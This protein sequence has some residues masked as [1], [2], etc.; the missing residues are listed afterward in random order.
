MLGPLLTLLITISALAE[1]GPFSVVIQPPEMKFCREVISFAEKGGSGVFFQPNIDK[2]FKHLPKDIPAEELRGIIENAMDPKSRDTALTRC[3]D[4]VKSIR[5]KNSLN[6]LSGTVGFTKITDDEDVTAKKREIEQ[7][8]ACEVIKFDPSCTVFNTSPGNMDALA[9]VSKFV[10]EKRGCDC[11]EE[12]MKRDYRMEPGKL[13][14]QKAASSERLRGVVLSSFGEKFLNDYAMN[15]EDVG[16]FQA[17]TAKFFGPDQATQDKVAMDYQCSDVKRYQNAIDFKCQQTGISNEEKQ[18]RINS[19]F[20]AFTNREDKKDVPLADRFNELNRKVQVLDFDTTGASDKY[21]RRDHD[22]KRFGLSRK[23]SSVILLND[24]VMHIMKSPALRIKL[25]QALAQNKKPMDGIASV[26]RQEASRDPKWFV[27]RFLKNEKISQ[28][29]KDKAFQLLKENQSSLTSKTD[30]YI[31]QIEIAMGIHPGIKAM[32]LDEAVFYRATRKAQADNK[33]LVEALEMDDEILGEKYKKRCQ[34]LVEKLTEAVCM[35]KKDLIGKVNANDLTSL[36]GKQGMVFNT[37]VEQLLICE[38]GNSER[39]VDTF[40]D[41]RMKDA[42]S[43]S[44]LLDRLTNAKEKQTNSFRRLKETKN[45]EVKEIVTEAIS[46]TRGMRQEVKNSNLAS[47]KFSAERSEKT[48]AAAVHEI[49]TPVASSAGAK[50][51]RQVESFESSSPAANFNMAPTAAPSAAVAARPVEVRGSDVRS[52]IRETISNK[53]NQDKVENLLSNTDDSGMKELLRLKEEGLRDRQKL[54]ELTNERERQ[55][56]KALEDK[57]KLLEE[58]KASVAKNKEEVSE[59]EPEDSRPRNSL[60]SLNREIASLRPID[61]SGSQSGDFGGSKSSSSSSAGAASVGRSGSGNSAAARANGPEKN[62]D[63]GSA[64]YIV[65]SGSGVSNDQSFKSQEVS[66]GLIDLLSTSDPDLTTL[67][68]LKDS[69]ML[70]K[71]KVMENGVLVE[72]EIL[73]DYKM[74]TEDAKKLVEAKLAK[75]QNPQVTDLDHQ[76]LAAK[77][78]H[79]F[80]ALKIILGEQLK[81]T[82]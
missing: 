14:E 46:E 32:M 17:N 36:L 9:D 29:Y 39:T 59:E 41:L 74:L 22:V 71:F 7:K 44:D 64:G 4:A 79:S 60:R 75:K 2:S 42:Y 28:N 21:S 65:V 68:K 47:N 18:G 25:K 13:E 49:V 77:R 57:I 63:S 19:I 26:L 53:D 27:E 5:F 43:R 35:P 81:N 73:V 72:K 51:T 20:S 11:L 62:S 34:D 67:T 33:S 40:N 30:L 38:A 78:V 80:Q 24:A 52:E 1:A 76:L 82:P 56:L 70:Y 45:E 23:E 50:T 3:T 6:P 10:L 31:E 69:G 55:K 16:F 12:H 37:R 8:R 54:L 48:V 15:M 61:T 66:Q 58:Q